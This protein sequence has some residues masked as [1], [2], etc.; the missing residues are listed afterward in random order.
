MVHHQIDGAEEDF[1]LYRGRNSAQ[2]VLSGYCKRTKANEETLDGLGDGSILRIEHSLTGTH[3]VTATSVSPG[4]AGVFIN[5]TV[6]VTAQRWE[7]EDV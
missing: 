5:F 2:A 6:S 4:P 1:L 7:G 3:Y